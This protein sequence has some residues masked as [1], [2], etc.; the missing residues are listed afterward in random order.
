LHNTNGT[1][2]TANGVY[3]LQDNTGNFN[4]ALGWDALGN[5]TNGGGNTA[6]G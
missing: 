1:A 6:V 5:N 2:N 3:A 4:T